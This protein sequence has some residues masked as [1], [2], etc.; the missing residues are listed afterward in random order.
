[1]ALSF[2]EAMFPGVFYL[3]DRR[4]SGMS[5]KEIESKRLWCLNYLIAWRLMELYPDKVQGIAGTGGLPL[6]SKR[7]NDIGLVYKDISTQGSMKLL[8][9]NPFG[10][11]ALEMLQTAPENFLLKRL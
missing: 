10:I 11:S 5:D 6:K 1:M 7:I 4:Y 8:E 2:I 9:T 3:W